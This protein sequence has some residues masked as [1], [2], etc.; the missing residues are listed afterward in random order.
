MIFSNNLSIA[1]FYCTS[2]YDFYSFNFFKVCFIAQ[3]FVY[4]HE[5]SIE[6]WKGY[7]VVISIILQMWFKLFWFISTIQVNYPYWFL[8][9]FN[10]SVAKRWASLTVI[11][12]LSISVSTI[13]LYLT[14]F[15]AL[16]LGAYK[17]KII[18]FSWISLSI[19]LIFPL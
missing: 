10:S 14:Y 13:S 8:C 18:A 7:A 3:N 19:A 6:T 11:V 17:L 2:L 15:D 5:C 9:M 4:L 1:D 12:Y 16:L